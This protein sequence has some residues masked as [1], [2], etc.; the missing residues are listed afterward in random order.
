MK[1]IFK[2]FIY[3]EIKIILLYM[4]HN[5]SDEKTLQELISKMKGKHLFV[6]IFMNGCEPCKKTKPE[7]DNISDKWENT[8]IAKIDKD[9]IEK[10]TE[11]DKF[12][13]E[14]VT[15]FPDISYHNEKGV[16]KYKGNSTTRELEQWIENT[17]NANQLQTN[18]SRNDVTLPKK[19]YKTDFSKSR[20]QIKNPKGGSKRK[21][22]RNRTR[23]N[24]RIKSRI[25]LK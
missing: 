2:I 4:K 5:V 1:R 7:W 15:G 21:R 25:K 17:I 8:I 6:L 3:N 9:V 18:S 22:T 11:K 13:L 19:I 20:N 23:R 14:N 10:K 12:N 24:R 16:Q